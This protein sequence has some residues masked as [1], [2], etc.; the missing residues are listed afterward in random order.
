MGKRGAH[1]DLQ[2]TRICNPK[3]IVSSSPATVLRGTSYPGKTLGFSLSASLKSCAGFCTLHCS[4]VVKRWGHPLPLV[5]ALRGGRRHPIG[6]CFRQ[7][8]NEPEGTVFSVHSVRASPSRPNTEY[9]PPCL[10]I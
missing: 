1:L 8:K 6:S 3:G 5:R 7:A 2:L 9:C 4:F 10:I